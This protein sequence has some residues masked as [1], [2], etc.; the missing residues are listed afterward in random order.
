MRARSRSRN[1][2]HGQEQSGRGYGSSQLL[3]QRKLLPACPSHSVQFFIHDPHPRT[4]IPTAILFK[5][6]AT[7]AD[8]SVVIRFP[9]PYASAPFFVAEVAYAKRSSG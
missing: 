2:R 3:T 5:K 1:A 4:I 7:R 6:N 9:I 8:N